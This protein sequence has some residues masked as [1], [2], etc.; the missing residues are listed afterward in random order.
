MVKVGDKVRI[1]L[2]DGAAAELHASLVNPTGKVGEVIFVGTSDEFNVA[3]EIPKEDPE[4]QRVYPEWF[5]EEEL[6]VVLDE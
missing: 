1:T 5:Y 6:E 2:T 4:D 3:V